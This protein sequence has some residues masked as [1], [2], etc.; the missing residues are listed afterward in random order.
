MATQEIPVEKCSLHV[1]DLDELCRVLQKGL[2]NNFK[3]VSVKTV[4][5]PDLTQKPFTLAAKGISG[6]PRLA[7]VGGVP[8]LVPLAQRDKV[9][10]FDTVASLVD[11]PG[12]F[13]IGA[14]AGRLCT[15]NCELMPNIV[16]TSDCT[17]GDNKSRA[18]M[19]CPDDG[20][21]MIKQY[22]LNEFYILGNLL[23]C[24]GKQGPV[25]EVKVSKR[26]GKENF[27]TNMRETLKA[28][29]GDKP[30]G[31]GGT[32]LIE[33]GKAKLHVMP[34]YSQVPLNSDAD[35]DSWLK[36]READAPLVCLSVLISHDPGLS[37]RVE[38]THCFRQFNE[39]GHY[40]YDTTPDEVSYHGYFVPA[41][42]M[43]RLDRPPT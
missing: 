17:H 10:N 8:Y 22:D 11:L 1:P 26:S 3:N 24:E 31:L 30:V 37:L 41:E 14:G 28:H 29:Y 35:V 12:A 9:Y 33:S 18:A 16:T 6:S 23:A 13:I 19:I 7:D 38:H 27:V 43:Y 42:Y 2:S 15:I 34:D 36:F 20:I 25:I 5:C 40:H 32:F 39:G 4:E 21:L